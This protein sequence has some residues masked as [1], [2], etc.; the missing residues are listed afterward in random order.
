[1]GMGRGWLGPWQFIG[2]RSKASQGPLWR[3]RPCGWGQRQSGAGPAS[4][5]PSY[6]IWQKLMF[7]KFKDLIS[8]R[9]E[10]AA[11]GEWWP[12]SAGM[13][14]LRTMGAWLARGYRG[15]PCG[16]KTRAHRSVHWPGATRSSGTLGSREEILCAPA[17]GGMSLPSC[18]THPEYTIHKAVW[19]GARGRLALAMLTDP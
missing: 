5:T 6:H 18:W 16:P 13:A 19:Q 9:A 2:Q 17:G 12:R 8:K 4:H 11:H 10:A 3:Q 1:M 15:G 7:S 14:S